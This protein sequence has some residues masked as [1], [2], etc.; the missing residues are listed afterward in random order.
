[1]QSLV[2]SGILVASVRRSVWIQDH[3]LSLSIQFECL[4]VGEPKGEAG[5]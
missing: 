3:D 5:R 2:V 4:F 1:M